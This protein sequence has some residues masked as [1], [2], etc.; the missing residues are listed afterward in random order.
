MQ[1]VGLICERNKKIGKIMRTHTHIEGAK[2]WLCGSTIAYI[3]GSKPRCKVFHYI[4]IRLHV[5]LK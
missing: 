3:R 2:D 5:L 1:C 4:S